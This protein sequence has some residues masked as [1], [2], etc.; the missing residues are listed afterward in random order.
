MLTHLIHDGACDGTGHTL[1]TRSPVS[2]VESLAYTLATPRRT[3]NF[4]LLYMARDMR[5]LSHV[6][7]R[8]VMTTHVSSGLTFRHG[9]CDM[10]VVQ[11]WSRLPS[12]I[13]ASVARRAVLPVQGRPRHPDIS[14]RTTGSDHG[15]R[16]SRQAARPRSGV[17]SCPF[18]KGQAAPRAVRACRRCTARAPPRRPRWATSRACRAGAACRLHS[19]RHGHVPWR[20]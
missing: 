20:C 4:T 1:R 9:R 5:T 11:R 7:M 3:C 8:S 17:M 6:H 14:P 2:C 15:G 12:P 13:R 10:E 19:S 16:C 18:Q